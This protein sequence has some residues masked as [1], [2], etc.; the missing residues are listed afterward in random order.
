MINFKDSKDLLRD[1]NVFKFLWIVEFPL[2]ARNEETNKLEST[3]HPFT[4]PI[5]E[6]VSKV[7]SNQ[8]LDSIKGLHYDLV[9]NGNEIAGGSIRVHDP[10]LQRHILANVLKEDTSQLEHLLEALEYG[11]PPHGGIAFGLDRLVA[12]ITGAKN[13]RDVIA[14]PKNQSGKDLMA[15][16]PSSVPKEELDFYRIQCLSD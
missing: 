4:A 14:F 3:H 13:I 15:S 5:P 12:I 6:H 16:A 7:I 8:D 10:H 2:F 11:A 9:L 1:P